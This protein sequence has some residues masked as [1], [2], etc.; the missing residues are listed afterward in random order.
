MADV[1]VEAVQACLGLARGDVVTVARTPFVD[2]VLL[3]GR[4]VQLDPLT[5]APLPPPWS[6]PVCLIERT[7]V[8]GPGLWLDTCPNCAT[9]M[10]PEQGV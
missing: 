9:T 3:G 2:A 7:D 4:L 8:E 6:C 10:P 5:G 1:M